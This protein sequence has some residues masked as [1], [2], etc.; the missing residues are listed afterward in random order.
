MSVDIAE[1]G[2]VVR[3]DGVI[4]ADQR[5]RKLQKAANDS[6]TA[7]DRLALAA[8][9]AAKAARRMGTS[10]QNVGRNMT[11]YVTAP[12]L[13]LS[14]AAV[15]AFANFDDAMVK[16]MAI[17]GDLSDT[18]K[19]DLAATARDVAKSTSF[20]A[21]QTAE[22]Y[23]FLAS[24]G[25]DAAQSMAALPRVAKFAQAGAF[26]MARATDILTDAQSALG[27]VM[28]D[29]IA[30][31][32]EMTELSDVLV[33]A[34]TLANASVE[35]FGRALTNKAGTAMRDLNIDIETGVAVLAAWADQGIKA[36]E[37]GE[38]FNIITRDLQTAIRKNGQV[39]KDYGISVFNAEGQIRNLADIIGDLER[40]LGPMS[41]EQRSATLALLGFQ[42]R[43]VIAI[44]SLIGMSE[45]IREYEAGLRKAGNTTDEVAA[46]QLESFKE[47][48]GL[49]KSEIADVAIEI[50]ATLAPVVLDLAKELRDLVKAFNELDEETQ[51]TIFKVGGIAMAMGPL[52]LI[53]GGLTKM[54]GPIIRHIPKLA[55]AFGLLA[56]VLWGPAG[57]ILGLIAVVEQWRFMDDKIADSIK[58]HIDEM[59][60]GLNRFRGA[61]G[62]LNTDVLEAKL[63]SMNDAIED[64]IQATR[65][66][67]G[68]WQNMEIDSALSSAGDDEA[69]ETKRK[70]YENNRIELENLLRTRDKLTA[71]LAEMR[72]PLEDENDI[73]EEIVVN[74]KRWGEAAN[75]TQISD[76]E[77]KDFAET[78]EDIKNQVLPARK[79][80]LLLAKARKELDRMWRAGRIDPDE[81]ERLNNLLDLAASRFEEVDFM[82][83]ANLETNGEFIGGLVDMRTAVEE[84]EQALDPA[85]A[86]LAQL[87]EM[88]RRVNEAYESGALKDAPGLYER[89]TEAIERQREALEGTNRVFEEGIQNWIQALRDVANSFDR[90]S[91]AAQD[92]HRM[93][94]LL[95][96]AT[97][98]Y[99]VIKHL[100]SG[101][102]YTA[103]PRAL[104]VA[105]MIASMGVQTGASS[106]GASMSLT[107]RRQT[108]Q[109]TGSILGDAMEKSESI[110]KSSQITA[111]ATSELVGI[112]RGMLHALQAVER[113]ISMAT[114]EISREYQ[115]H[116]FQDPKLPNTDLFG[117]SSNEL[118]LAG[119]AIA[120]PFGGVLLGALASSAFG[121]TIATVIGAGAFTAIGTAI[122]PIFGTILG[123]IFGSA[124]GKLLGGKSKIV[125]RGVV[126][127][128]GTLEDAIDGMLIQAYA[129][130]K[131]KKWRWGSTRRRDEYVELDDEVSTQIALIFQSIGDTVMAGAVAL[132]MDLDE[133]EALMESFVIP[134]MTISLE[135]LSGEEIEAE[136]QAVFGEIFD[137]L[138]GHVVPWIAEFQKVG[139]GLGETLVRV[140]T[141]VQVFDQVLGGMMDMFD[142]QEFARIAVHMMELSGG[143]DEFISR[144]GTF[145]DKFGPEEMKLEFLEDQLTSLFDQFGLTLPETRE[146]F[147][148]L[149]HG[150]DITTE[151]GR[152]ALAMMLE[153]SSTADQYYTMAAQAEEERL[154]I[155][156]DGISMLA[157]WRGIIEDFMDVS[158][159][160]LVQ[161]EESFTEAMEAAKALNAS[162]KEYAM[163]TRRFNAE[164][165]RMAAQLT[166]NVLDMAEAL[167]GSGADDNI[168]DGMTDGLG[169]VREVANQ[170]WEDWMRA[171][172]RIDEFLN[173]ILLDEQLTT[174]TPQEQ[175][176][177]AQRQFYRTLADARAGDVE[178]A[179]ALPEIAKKYLEEARFMYASGHEYTAIFN[180][181]LAALESIQMPGGIEP[182]IIEEPD[183]EP[184]WQDQADYTA[185]ALYNSLERFL[186]ASDLA[187]AL[188]DLSQVLGV[189]VI[190]LAE[191]LKIP[192]DQ[193]VELLGVELDSL[194]VETAEALGGVADMLGA[195]IFELM[196]ALGIDIAQLAV[197]FGVNVEDMSKLLATQ[198]G[199]FSAALGA[200]VFKLA[201]ALGVSIDDLAATFDLGIEEFTSEQWSSL[202]EFSDSLGTSLAETTRQLGIDLGEIT[203][204]TSI[205]SEVFSAEIEKLP[206]NIQGDLGPYL[207]AIYGATTEADANQAIQD[208][209]DYILTLPEEFRDKLSPFLELM[210]YEKLMPE[211]RYLSSIDHALTTTNNLLTGILKEL[212]ATTKEIKAIKK[213]A[214]SYKYPGTKD[215]IS[216]YK[217][218]KYQSG[219]YVDE[220]GPAYLHA[221]EFVVNPHRNNLTAV[222]PS[223][224]D[225][226]EELKAIRTLL[227][228]IKE[229]Q[230]R[231]QDSDLETTR[232]MSSSMKQQAEQTR[233]ANYG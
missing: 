60:E 47:Q 19:K 92:L 162:Q 215:P 68:E 6:A 170:L 76:E 231:Y 8:D 135:D 133:I 159:R 180:A 208:L 178:A 210:G 185:T 24:A 59:T 55:G 153:V 17:M 70:A 102:V 85:G 33:K 196:D 93:I 223:D 116:G 169:E 108:E 225:T 100:A 220:T 136:L 94:V 146:G 120:T 201:E 25:M 144:F 137:N 28:K 204:A 109:G 101:D 22:A 124:L 149:A 206:E 106:G 32:K 29:P 218:P 156:E 12:M 53:F 16:S 191:E 39:F 128:S 80:M 193:L 217:Y 145:F 214:G 188:R 174:L 222:A 175:L 126:I 216:P 139:E 152:E 233:R 40:A 230:R 50:G 30:N 37:A 130:I 190:A 221:G 181:V 72:Q 142:P 125:D 62:D 203:D 205:L 168:T 173:D 66:S 122:A 46:R 41:T 65:D 63:L 183:D 132:G 14:G 166:L 212:G 143:I 74:V 89:V 99:A 23:Y 75:E 2:L 97:G 213:D 87:D 127:L 207:D 219:G 51:Q 172:E 186:K 105:A 171:L 187:R 42:D 154:E 115:M 64:Q 232:E 114:T 13:A 197:A 176:F 184:G 111:D 57:V 96:V 21:S 141:S 195:D 160:P 83:Q 194:T 177:E 129:T 165:R 15:S 45:K 227:S 107:E 5:L 84:I 198:L 199:A 117:L 118:G 121:T 79:E 34:A 179:D 104:A 163:I 147:F 3:S 224:R 43:S 202:V 148:E 88:Q 158:Y 1:L 123:Y 164:L 103:I 134:E 157:T 138:A 48:L 31:M 91:Q 77:F 226:Q 167:F 27:R 131:Y 20:S 7:A 18:M 56:R 112:N 82:V 150:M 11:M 10:M 58:Q 200:D 69:L 182:T 78:M 192:L 110:E 54:L 189:S 38:K 61:I 52:L 155:L 71:D 119:A 209:G 26:D 44:R 86:A 161:L 67:L 113:G 4:V 49:V 151:S 36:E 90:D 73:L 211:L 95:Q 98:I 81:F 228:D 35:Q 140:A 229:Q 9:R